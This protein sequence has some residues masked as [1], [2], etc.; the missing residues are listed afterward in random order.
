MARPKKANATK[1]QKQSQ[2]PPAPIRVA[3]WRYKTKIPGVK[4]E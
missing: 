4:E 1:T 3:I 2:T